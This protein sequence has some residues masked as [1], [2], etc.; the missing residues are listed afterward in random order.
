MPVWWGHD[1]VEY[2]YNTVQFFTVLLTYGIAMTV[3]ALR[4]DVKLA[5][6]FALTGEQWSVCC[7][8]IGEN[9]QSYIGNALYWGP[10]MIVSYL[11]VIHNKNTT[12]LAHDDKL[13]DVFSELKAWPMYT[14][15]NTAIRCYILYVI[16]GPHGTK[17]TDYLAFNIVKTFATIMGKRQWCIVLHCWFYKPTK[18]GIIP[19]AL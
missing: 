5:T 11:Q 16:K 13:C 10:I 14:Y 18:N 19:H 4:S 9:W 15:I 17:D 1:T 8:D 7:K 3:A 6:D 12:Q 2:H